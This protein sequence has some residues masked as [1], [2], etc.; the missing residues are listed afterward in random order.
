MKRKCIIAIVLMIMFIPASQL[1]A[2][3]QPQVSPS[4]DYIIGP[5]DVLDI[6]VWDN[7]ALTK[8]VTVLPD[9]KIHFPLI[10]EVIVGG[11]TLADLEKELKERIGTFVPDTD[12]LVMVQETSSL[13]IYVI[14]EVNN[15]GRFKFNSNINV[16]QAL[17]L[18]G[19]FTMW[20]KKNK[21]KIFR[22]TKNKTEVLN[23][24]YDDIVK[25][26][27]IDSNIKLKRGDTIFVPY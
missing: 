1:W 8:L 26:K 2:S 9:G 23:F 25:E 13:M 14:G 7:P 17:A 4:G 15:P 24:S 6:S 5:G 22:E 16:L 20:A 18:A 19:G 21:I 3:D 10:G 11:R 27:N 12:L